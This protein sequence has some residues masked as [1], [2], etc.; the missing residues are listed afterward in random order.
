MSHHIFLWQW[1]KLLKEGTVPGSHI[2]CHLAAILIVTWQPYWL[3][4]GSH[5]D[6]HLA[7]ILIVTWQ[8]Y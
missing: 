2:G 6:C 5:I 8:P 3:S 1:H 7:A 4:P